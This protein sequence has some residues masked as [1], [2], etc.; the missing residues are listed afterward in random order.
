MSEMSFE[1]LLEESLVTIYN[2]EVVEGTVIGV[3]EDEII[4][5][6]GY[7]ADGIITRSEYTN[8][9]NVDL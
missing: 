6:I 1:Q 2:G 5:N 8:T 7:K 9:P 3:K 4:L